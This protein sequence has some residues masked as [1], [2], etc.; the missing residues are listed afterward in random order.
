MWLP[1]MPMPSMATVRDSAGAVRGCAAEINNPK[2]LTATIITACS[3][4]AALLVLSVV[5]CWAG[6]AHVGA[7]AKPPP[8]K[9]PPASAPPAK[10]PPASAPP[11]SV[12]DLLEA[13]RREQ[14]VCTAEPDS[15]R[16]QRR[17]TEALGMVRAAEM[18]GAEPS[19]AAPIRAALEALDF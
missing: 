14:A 15:G 6:R 18:M 10:A 12:G 17:V 13:A 3:V 9:A 7:A 5:S 1:Q 11:A 4:F 16:R 2:L 19:R 8:A